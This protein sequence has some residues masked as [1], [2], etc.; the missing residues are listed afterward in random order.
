VTNPTLARLIERYARRYGS[1]SALGKAIGLSPSRMSRLARGDQG[2]L[3][4]INC[5]KLAEL[6]GESPASI[7][8]SADKADVAEL[9]ERL[10]QSTGRQTTI[11]PEL[12][13]VFERV[14]LTHTQIAELLDV[15]E[16]LKAEDRGHWW[17][18][19]KASAEEADRQRGVTNGPRPLGV[20][21]DRDG[22]PVLRPASPRHKHRS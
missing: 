19:L 9:I 8:R 10:Y 5:L 20:G 13:A 17:E 22:R 12:Q 15:W 3:E 14:S 4:V 2:S 11:L 6:T 16:R 1:L 7:L 18:L 21:R